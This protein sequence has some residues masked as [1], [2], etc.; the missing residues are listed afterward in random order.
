KSG[1][2][3]SI[4]RL[5]LQACECSSWPSSPQ[6]L[7]HGVLAADKGLV[8]PD[9]GPIPVAAAIC[10]A[11]VVQESVNRG[12]RRRRLQVEDHICIWNVHGVA[13]QYAIG[14][15]QHPASLEVGDHRLDAVLR[16]PIKRS[17]FLGVVALG[18]EAPASRRDV[19][20][21]L[22]MRRAESGEKD[23]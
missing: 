18:L 7:L 17:I 9:V 19:E 4:M 23:V 6:N 5:R 21:R 22:Q 8:G 13:K 11:D 2:N 15:A 14:L 16:T 3:C 20:R 12:R 1:L 10:Y